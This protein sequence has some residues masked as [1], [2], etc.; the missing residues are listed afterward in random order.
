LSAEIHH[1]IGE[2]DIQTIKSGAPWKENCYLVRHLPTGEQ[3]VIDPGA[4][5]E[6]IIRAVIAN[7]LDLA[8]LWLTHAHHDHIVAVAG[9]CRHF[10]ISCHLHKADQR[11]LRHGPM[12]A[13]RFAG[14]QIEAPT[15]VKL[16]ETPCQFQLGGSR[17]DIIHTPGHTPGGVCYSLEG[18]VFTGDILTYEHVG[19]TDLPGGDETL[20]KA[21]VNHILENLPAETVLFGGHGRPWTVHQARSWWQTAQSDPPRVDSFEKN[22]RVS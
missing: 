13:L 16:F 6:T 2:F 8:Q 22:D 15:D 9:L 1:C 21:S 20:I 11:L 18:F 3:A 5:A 10:G 14:L 7:G 17:V 19:R 4:D 12:Y